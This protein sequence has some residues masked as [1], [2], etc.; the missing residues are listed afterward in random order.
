[1]YYGKNVGG[2]FFK[3]DTWGSYCP[4]LPE[5]QAGWDYLDA[6]VEP[7]RPLPSSSA[8]NAHRI[9]A[10][11]GRAIPLIEGLRPYVK[12]SIGYTAQTV[13]KISSSTKVGLYCIQLIKKLM[14]LPGVR[15]NL[16]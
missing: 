16:Q 5:P 4:N 15:H 2:L 9:Y 7:K 6:S 3:Q 13:Q 11:D 14:R 8:Y 1:V 10:P 12:G